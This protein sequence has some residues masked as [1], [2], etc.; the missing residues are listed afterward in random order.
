MRNLF[1]LRRTLLP[2]GF[3]PTC[4]LR[5]SASSTPNL[6]RPDL[7]QGNAY[8][9]KPSLLA[10]NKRVA[11]VDARSADYTAIHARAAATGDHTEIKANAQVMVDQYYDLATDFYEFGWGE[12]F[13]FGHRFAH[14]TL[15]ESLVRHE[16]YLASRLGLQPGMHCLDVGCGVGGPARNIARFSGAPEGVGYG[17]GG[18]LE[19]GGYVGVVRRGHIAFPSLLL[20]ARG[21]R[22]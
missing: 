8:A 17:G 12:S 21:S 14:E 15:K 2:A 9:D 20:Q 7:A 1:S 10:V 13:H 22:A 18:G 5:L 11:G 6:S 3:T 16:Y 19:G 4:P